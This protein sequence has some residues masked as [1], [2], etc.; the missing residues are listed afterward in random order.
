VRPEKQKPLRATEAL[1][2]LNLTTKTDPVTSKGASVRQ[3]LWSIPV[4][5]IVALAFMTT[6]AAAAN[7]DGQAT[8]ACSNVTVNG[9]KYVGQLTLTFGLIGRVSCNEAH[10][11]VRAYFRKMAAGQCGAQNNFC[12]LRFA[13]GWDCS[14]FFATESQETGGAIYGCARAGAK[15]RLYKASPHAST[16][17]TLH[18]SEFRSPD[19]EI[20]CIVSDVPPLGAHLFCNGFDGHPE[21]IIE[22]GKVGVCNKAAGCSLGFANGAPIL[23]YGQRTEA[24]GFRCTS[25]TS[26]ITCIRTSTGK[27]SESTRT[28]PSGLGDLE[29]ASEES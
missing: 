19:K 29:C 8:S 25:A 22:R 28:K 21:G 14:I 10:S 15:V 16:H 13:G 23:A 24:H 3:R 17:G 12:N 11:V 6:S 4:V 20:G 7:G 2:M 18:L 26:G 5:V 27:A 9:G 1:A